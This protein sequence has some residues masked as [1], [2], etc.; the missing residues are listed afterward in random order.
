MSTCRAHLSDFVHLVTHN[1]E[2]FLLKKILAYFVILRLTLLFDRVGLRGRCNRKG[3]KIPLNL[4]V[5]CIFLFI[6]LNPVLTEFN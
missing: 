5:S 4:E 1:D 2:S 3:E 6:F